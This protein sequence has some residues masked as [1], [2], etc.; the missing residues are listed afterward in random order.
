MKLTHAALLQI[1][2]AIATLDAGVDLIVEGKTVRKA[3]KLGMVPRLSLA[4]IGIA[5]KPALEAYGKASQQLFDGADPEA[6][7]T[8][9][10][11]PGRRVPADR[12]G[13]YQ[14]ELQQL[15][16]AVVDVKLGKYRF[17]LSE[18][19]TGTGE[20]ENAIPVQ[21]IIDLMPILID[22]TAPADGAEDEG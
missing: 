8:E 5:I 19:K 20:G 3:F 12:L 1:S 6:Y 18:L 22:D 9:K 11:E 4:R 14:A 13:A 7:T 10:G 15:L 21:A 17:K 2:R 16:E